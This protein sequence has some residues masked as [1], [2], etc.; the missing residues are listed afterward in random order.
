[1]VAEFEAKMKAMQDEINSKRDDEA[2]K[3]D[4]LKREAEMRVEMEKNIEQEKLKAQREETD[5][6]ERIRREEAAIKKR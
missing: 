2:A 1:M 3:D 5:R 4:A 6:L